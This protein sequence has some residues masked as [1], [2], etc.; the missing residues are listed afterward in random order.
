MPSNQSFVII[1]A[2]HAGGRAAQAMRAA[3]F[4]GRIVLIGEEPYEPYERPPLSKELL[5]TDEGLE[6]ARLHERAWYDEQKIELL[7][8]NAAVMLDPAS[9]EVELADGACIAYDKL[10]LTTGA[11]VRELPVPGADLPG[12]HYLR[13]FDDTLA[14]RAALKPGAR[15][16]V[17]GGG[18]IGLECAA[19]AHARDC[20]VTVLEMA[21]RL[22]GRAVAPEIGRCFE[23]LHRGHGVDLRLGVKILGI[24]G[25]GKVERVILEGADP[26][27]ADLIVVGIGILPNAELAAEAGI[28]V[29]N[30]IT[31]DEFG[32]TSD[33]RIFAAGDV[34]NQPND[35]L[36]RRVRLESYQNAQDHAAAVARNMLG[37]E[38]K[39]YQDSLWVWSDQYDTNLQMLGHPD[40][41][42]ALVFRGDP[43]AGAFTAFYMKGPKIVAVN[44]VNSGRDMGAS[45][46]LLAS[47]KDFDAAQLA[48][49]AVKLIKLAKG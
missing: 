42:D 27:S 3:G 6:K 30:G 21:D 47:G 45:K 20:D 35:F 17:I 29:D 13:S 15:L 46:R 34:A 37:E 32:R 33:E 49:P 28:A 40:N 2:G 8:G 23:A 1:G 10:L 9:R 5:A 18:F 43:D 11:R 24:E 38:Q 12:L 31:V 39:P 16:V 26:L 19:S 48:D 14:I 22:M 7:T 4:E 25:A 41:Y 36:G 44:T